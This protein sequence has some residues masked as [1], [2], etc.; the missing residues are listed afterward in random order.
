MT[1]KKTKLIENPDLMI[2]AG[3]PQGELG[4][5]LIANMNINHENLAQ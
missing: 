1:H 4:E 5:Q 2:N 3:N